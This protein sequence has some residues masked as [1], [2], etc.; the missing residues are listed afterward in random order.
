MVKPAIYILWTAFWL[1]F[2]YKQCVIDNSGDYYA[3]NW[4]AELM[5]TG[6][7]TI[8]YP[9]YHAVVMVVSIVFSVSTYLAGA[10]V[11]ALSS[12]L[13]LWATEKLICEIVYRNTLSKTRVNDFKIL[14]CSILV[15]IVQ[16]IFT[17]SIRPGYSSGNGYVSP[18]QAFVKP[19]IIF[20]CLIEYR[21][22]TSAESG[23]RL[24]QKKNVINQI[25]LTAVLILS[26]LAKPMFAMA[27]I[28][29]MGIYWLVAEIRKNDFFHNFRSFGKVVVGYLIDV[30]PLILSGIVLIIQ[31]VLS[32]GI[33][34][35][36]IRAGI[37]GNTS[38]EFGWMTAWKLCVSNVYLSILFAYFA[39]IVFLLV[40]RKKLRHLTYWKFTGIYT[41]IS[42]LMISCLY[43]SGEY[44]AD[45][46]F[47]NA[48]VV[49]FTL[50]YTGCFSEMLGMK[51]DKRTWA[52]IVLF[53][54][55]LLFGLALIAKDLL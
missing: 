6:D 31:Y 12:F 40:N 4:M 36:P 43:Q 8:V 9:L 48:W 25:V 53:G 21:I 27:F 3:H 54:I 45:L 35:N 2:Y 15:N 20:A 34:D 47:R 18:T 42:F 13:T 14:F 41:L 11:L 33:T 32:M 1:I 23:E 38:I 26:C 50:I 7:I 28:P 24:T 52:T 49:A 16:P 30:Y 46:N 22:I 39:P 44:I 10:I 5:K 17:Y 55:H 19:I 37:D 51:K 29:A